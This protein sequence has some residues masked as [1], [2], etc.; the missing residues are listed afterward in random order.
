M[1]VKEGAVENSSWNTGLEVGV[2]ETRKLE[3]LR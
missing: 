2:K 3:I 1:I